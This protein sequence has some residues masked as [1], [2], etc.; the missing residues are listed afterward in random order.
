MTPKV[1]SEPKFPAVF[2][3]V[4]RFSF[5]TLVKIWCDEKTDSFSSSFFFRFFLSV[6]FPSFALPSPAFLVPALFFSSILR[7]G[8]SFSPF[9]IF[10]LSSFPSPPRSAGPSRGYC[11][12]WFSRLVFLF[13]LPTFLFFFPL[14]FL[15]PSAGNYMLG[16]FPTFPYVFSRTSLMEVFEIAADGPQKVFFR[17][18][19]NLLKIFLQVSPSRHYV[20]RRLF[21]LPFSYLVFKRRAFLC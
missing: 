7:I 15:L 4:V 12:V 5:S 18:H 2:G 20:F 3:F 16:P 17:P 8:D 21:G 10:F 1:F 13:F 11:P 9:T 19:P 14:T 6:L